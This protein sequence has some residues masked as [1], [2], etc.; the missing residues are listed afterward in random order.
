MYFF[1]RRH[2][3]S[4]HLRVHK[5]YFSSFSFTFEQCTSFSRCVY[6]CMCGMSSCGLRLPVSAARSCVFSCFF[7]QM[8]LLTVHLQVSK[9][10]K[11]SPTITFIACLIAAAGA[12]VPYY[13]TC[14]CS[15]FNAIQ[16]KYVVSAL[17]VLIRQWNTPILFLFQN[18]KTRA[19]PRPF[20]S[21]ARW[22]PLHRPLPSW[23]CRRASKQVT[24]Y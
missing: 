20:A 6:I 23:L 13:W 2:L 12:V 16:P 11:C 14:V 15:H 21:S 18:H 4:A 17:L 19:L 24:V 7:S 3:E 5:R 10:S 8:R 1:R 9:S 22:L